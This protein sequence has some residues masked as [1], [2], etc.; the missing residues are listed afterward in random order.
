VKLSCPNC[1][2]DIPAADANL[3]RAMA[4]CRQC[5]EVFGFG[6]LLP[7]TR[8]PAFAG[9]ALP[10]AEVSL[11]KGYVLSEDAGRFQLTHRWFSPK[12][13]FFVFFS[14]FWNG[15][16]SVFVTAIVSGQLPLPVLAFLS[17]HIAVGLGMAYFTL[18]MFVNRTV[19]EIDGDRLRVQHRPLPWPGARDLPVAD[20]A[21]LFCREKVTHGKNGTSVTYE[22]HASLRS[23]GVIKLLSGLDVPEQALFV[24]QQLE[25]RLGIRDE[26]VEGELAR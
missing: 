19:V 7:N 25:G 13:F 12:A 26:P 10:R 21:Q 15:I 20:L 23:G 14:L 9:R 24:E 17:L 18:C 16:V 1:K 11:P 22:L 8:G 6:E 5:N 3:E 4:R 2:V